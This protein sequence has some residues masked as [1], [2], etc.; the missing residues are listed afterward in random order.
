MAISWHAAHKLGRVDVRDAT[1]CKPAAEL[2]CRITA[3]INV[4]MQ[5]PWIGVYAVLWVSGEEPSS[6]GIVVSGAQVIEA[7]V[8]VVLFAAIEVVV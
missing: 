8:R 7:E 2:L 6:A 4:F 5:G 3:R 1:F